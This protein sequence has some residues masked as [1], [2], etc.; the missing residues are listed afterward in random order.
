MELNRCPN[1]SGKLV[2]SSDR[3]KMECPYCGSEFALTEEAKKTIENTPVAN[4]SLLS[5]ELLTNL[6]HQQRSKSLCVIIR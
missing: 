5:Q 2:L 4:V 1:C 6:V 3:K